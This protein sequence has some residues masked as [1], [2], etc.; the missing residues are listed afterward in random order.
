MHPDGLGRLWATPT[1]KA[2]FG[3]LERS[4][5]VG[6]PERPRGRRYLALGGWMVSR[7]LL[8]PKHRERGC[9]RVF[10]SFLGTVVAKGSRSVRGGCRTGHSRPSSTSKRMRPRASAGSSGQASMMRCR[11]GSLEVLSAL[12]H[13]A[14]RL[15]IFRIGVF[16]GDLAP[17]DLIADPPSSVRLRRGVSTTLWIIEFEPS[18]THGMAPKDMLLSDCEPPGL[19][20]RRL[21]S[22]Q[23]QIQAWQEGSVAARGVSARRKWGHAGKAVASQAYTRT[24][25][26]IRCVGVR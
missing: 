13:C 6:C 26:L 4:L 9:G 21:G 19:W 2:W 23:Y 24:I 3:P 1:Q 10:S 25:W 16:L 18:W 22:P 5:Q 12:A 20:E 17:G 15:A 7:A 11:S 8:T 14:W